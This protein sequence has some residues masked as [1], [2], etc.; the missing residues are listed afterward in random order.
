V[1]AGALARRRPWLLALLLVGAHIVV[2][3]LLVMVALTV[4]LAVGGPE[5]GRDELYRLGAAPRLAAAG[6]VV[7]VIVAA[8]AT[9]VFALSARP[10][11]AWK[12]PAIGMVASVALCAIALAF[13]HAP[14]PVVGG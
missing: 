14:A 6:A 10:Q 12:A 7:P 4:S 13:L 8:T 11:D 9:F 3:A 2:A 1:S 5:I